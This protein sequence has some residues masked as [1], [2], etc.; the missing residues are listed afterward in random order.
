MAEEKHLGELG[1]VAAG[2]NALTNEKLETKKDSENAH[3]PEIEDKI[4]VAAVVGSGGGV[5]S[6]EHHEKKEA[7]EED[8]EARRKMLRNIFR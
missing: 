1:T 3:K 4:G 6:H 8:E 7:N 5:T 2:A